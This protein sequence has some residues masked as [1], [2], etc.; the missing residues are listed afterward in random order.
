MKNRRLRF[1]ALAVLFLGSVVLSSP[2]H[3]LAA[4]QSEMRIAEMSY[5]C[6]SWCGV[7]G[8]YLYCPDKQEQDEEC[9]NHCEMNSCD[10]CGTDTTDCTG[11]AT[12]AWW[13]D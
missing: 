6:G 10:D 9:Q 8:E 3:T 12:H 5:M 7:C 11:P 1:H 13:C 2:E 4:T